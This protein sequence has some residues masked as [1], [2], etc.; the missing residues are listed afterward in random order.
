MGNPRQLTTVV[1]AKGLMV[2]PKV[3]LD[4]LHWGPGTRLSIESAQGGILL[5]ATPVFAASNIDALFGSMRHAGPALSI[6]DMNAAIA[7][8]AAD[9]V[10][11]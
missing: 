11:D 10:R 4:Q 8:D 7:R 5:K 1:S 3:I 2:L 6:D 9:R